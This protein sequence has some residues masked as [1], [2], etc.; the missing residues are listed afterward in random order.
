MVRDLV[1]QMGV[2]AGGCDASV[3]Q[4]L[5]DGADINTAFKKMG[6]KGMSQRMDRRL[7]VDTAL[8]KSR[9][10]SILHRGNVDVLSFPSRKEPLLCPG[11]SPEFTQMNQSWFGKRYATVFTAFAVTHPEQAPLTIDILDPETG[12]FGDPQSAGVDYR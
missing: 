1:G 6:G 9:F 3:S 7:L 10:E 8:K 11:L 4:N 2:Y 12:C 5:L